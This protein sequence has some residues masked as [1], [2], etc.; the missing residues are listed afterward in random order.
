MLP[1]GR[2]QRRHAC[3]LRRQRRHACA[4]QLRLAGF[5]SSQCRTLRPT[6]RPRHTET[7]YH[8]C[9]R[10]RVDFLLPWACLISPGLAVQHRHGQQGRREWVS[11]LPS[12]GVLLVLHMLSLDIF[13]APISPTFATV[14]PTSAPSSPRGVGA[15]LE[16]TAQILNSSWSPRCY[17]RP[18]G[19]SHRAAKWQSRSG[20]TLQCC[21]PS[22]ALPPEHPWSL[23]LLSAAGF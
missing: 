16:P 8:V 3:A 4:L 9:E 13:P 20:C 21:V 17:T 12:T 11:G 14:G 15:G 10:E 5:L 2:R 22:P 7:I 1:S 18:A 23:H 6:Q 19:T